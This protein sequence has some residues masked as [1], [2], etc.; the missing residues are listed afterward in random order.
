MFECVKIFLT[1]HTP[2]VAKVGKTMSV[3]AHDNNGTAAYWS[4][5][6]DAI[7]RHLISCEGKKW[8]KMM[9][10]IPNRSKSAI[11]NRWARIKKRKEK[12]VVK[13][14][15]YDSMDESCISDDDFLLFKK[16]TELLQMEEELWITDKDL[17]GCVFDLIPNYAFDLNVKN[18]IYAIELDSSKWIW[19]NTIDECIGR[20]INRMTDLIDQEGACER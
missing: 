9:R 20:I 8:K 13:R 17:K 19:N 18:A 10:M 7:V 11:R 6:E 3:D 14:T 16:S 1:S 4:C 5:E 15:N 12:M 2:Y